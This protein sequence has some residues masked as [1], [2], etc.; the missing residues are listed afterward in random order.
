MNSYD[1]IGEGGRGA[2]EAHS[3]APNGSV[4]LSTPDSTL[5]LTLATG[6]NIINSFFPVPGASLSPSENRPTFY[7]TTPIYYAN[8]RPH[9]GS[10][11][12]TLVADVIARFKRM[13]GL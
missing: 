2:G 1:K 4:I 5:D 9:V 11:Y 13:H 10:A 3:I 8:A 6:P 12:T 7:L